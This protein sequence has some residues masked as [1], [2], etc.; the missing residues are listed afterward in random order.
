MQEGV[1]EAGL[2]PS[3]VDPHRY[4]DEVVVAGVDESRPQ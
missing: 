2:R 1:G 3:Q 4:F